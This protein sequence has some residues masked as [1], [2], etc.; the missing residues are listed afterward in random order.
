METVMAPNMDT[1]VPVFA[2]FTWWWLQHK[3]ART[4]TM[5]HFPWPPCRAEGQSC[6]WSRLLDFW[7]T[8]MVPLRIKK[9]QVH[10]RVRSN[11]IYLYN[12]WQGEG[13]EPV[14]CTYLYYTVHIAGVCSIVHGAYVP[15]WSHYYASWTQSIETQWRWRAGEWM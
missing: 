4:C 15:W 9:Q 1:W 7:N 14:V 2:T 13:S 3:T 12:F 6:L 8:F 10:W 5:E 11:R